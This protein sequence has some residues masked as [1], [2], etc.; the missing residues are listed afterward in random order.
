MLKL[1][2]GKK[3]YLVALATAVYGVS[4]FYTG[5]MPSGD[6]IEY[7]LLAAGLIGIRDGMNP[8]VKRRK[9]RKKTVKK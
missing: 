2:K 9:R 3:T 7:I 6:M 5:N 8:T 4:G 1:L